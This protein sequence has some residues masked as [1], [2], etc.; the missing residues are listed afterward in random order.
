MILEQRR[1]RKTK[2]VV[3][4]CRRR[5]SLYPWLRAWHYELECTEHGELKSFAT[6]ARAKAMMAHPDEWCS[7]CEGLINNGEGEDR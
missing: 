1:N 2:T 7:E 6:K 3:T 5:F 4:L